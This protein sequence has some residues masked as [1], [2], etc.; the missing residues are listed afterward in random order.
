MT[1]L[2][3]KPCGAQR[4]PI[5]SCT[6]ERLAE[7]H[8]LHRDLLIATERLVALIDPHPGRRAQAR[9]DLGRLG[10]F[11]HE[12]LDFDVG[13]LE[14][15]IALVSTDSGGELLGYCTALCHRPAVEA[16]GARLLGWAGGRRYRDAADLPERSPAGP[17]EWT[18]PA[19]A[20]EAFNRPD[21][22]AVGPEMAVRRS[23]VRRASRRSG[24]GAAL[25]GAV[26]RALP[27]GAFIL[28]EIFEIEGVNGI[29]V[30]PQV[31]NLGSQRVMQGLGGTKVG[32]VREGWC[33][34]DG[35]RLDVAWG[36]WLLPADTLLIHPQVPDDA[37]AVAA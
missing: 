17:L 30:S 19:R 37:A 31:C 7:V 33:R 12:P 5:V 32:L 1:L 28:G 11:L 29:A 15:N 10:G 3:D 2:T 13:T 22:L 4:L 35:T 36:L 21:R 27:L 6:A 18:D 26:A 16:Y 25:L 9:T 8:R 34:L 14:Q 20:I 23:E 24:L